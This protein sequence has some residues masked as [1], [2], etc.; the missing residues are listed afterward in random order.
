[1]DTTETQ[2]QYRDY[3]LEQHIPD[4]LLRQ[5]PKSAIFVAKVLFRLHHATRN[6]HTGQTNTI[7]SL[8]WIAKNTGYSVRTIH[9]AI[10]RLAALGIIQHIHRWAKQTKRYL[11]NF[12]YIP[13]TLYTM[14]RQY[15]TR[16]VLNISHMKKDAPIVDKLSNNNRDFDTTPNVSCQNPVKLIRKQIEV[17]GYDGKIHVIDKL[18]RV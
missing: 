3:P 7:P 11:T 18:Y 17:I 15:W 16:P 5:L 9:T 1:M 12:Y 6:T 8:K 13:K 10:H 4:Q 2:T 14:L